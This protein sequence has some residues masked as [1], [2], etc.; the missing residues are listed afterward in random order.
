MQTSRLGQSLEIST[1]HCQNGRVAIRPSNSGCK[2]DSRRHACSAT[3]N[4]EAQR[5]IVLSYTARDAAG[6]RSGARVRLGKRL[7]GPGF[8][9]NYLSLRS[10]A[11]EIHVSLRPIVSRRVDRWPVSPPQRIV[12]P[13]TAQGLDRRVARLEAG[14][15]AGEPAGR[16]RSA[17]SRSGQPA[18]SPGRDRLP[19][20]TD[21]ASSRAGDLVGGPRGRGHRPGPGRQPGPAARPRPSG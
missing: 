21:Q 18:Q 1:L 8:S 20:R 19:D 6:N 16:D 17:R 14:S 4:P 12:T 5:S 11:S 10:L 2:N 7:T 13:A 9:F 3:W 15:L